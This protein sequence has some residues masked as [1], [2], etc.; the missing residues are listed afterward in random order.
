MIENLLII[1]ID[2]ILFIFYLLTGIT[3]ALIIQLV[4]YQLTGFSIY[5]WLIKK[6]F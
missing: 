4:V 6:L 3:I 5:K 2:F 1:F